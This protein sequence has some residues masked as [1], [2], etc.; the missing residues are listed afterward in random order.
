MNNQYGQQPGAGQYGQQPGAGQYGQQPG[1]S[2]YGQQPGQFVQGQAP[3]QYGQQGAGQYGQQPGAGQYGQQ[4]P[5]Q[6]GVPISQP[7]N[8]ATQESK[9]EKK[10]IKLNLTLKAKDLRNVAGAFK[11]MSDPYAT[12]TVFSYRSHNPKVIGKTEVVKNTLSP[13][14]IKNFPLDYE[15]GTSMN[16]VINIFDEVRKGKNITMGSAAID[17]N[18]LLGATGNVMAVQMK[19]GGTIIARLDEPKGTGTLRLK[20][21]GSKLKNVEGGFLGKSDPFFQ[22]MKKRFVTTGYEWDPVYKSNVVMDNLNP[23]WKED[24]IQLSAL[25]EGDLDAPLQLVCFDHERDG[26]HTPM[27][28][29][30]TT[31]NDIVRQKN[32]KGFYLVN[33]KGK[34]VGNLIVRIAE[35][36]GIEKKKEVSKSVFPSAPPAPVAMVAQSF[37]VAAPTPTPTPYTPTPYTPVR[38]QPP[39]QATFADY[40]RG[41]CEMSLCVAIDFT[42][43]NGDPRQPGTLHHTNP[44]QKND[45]EKA[46]MAIGGVLA[47]YDTDNQFPVWGFGAKYGG[48]VYH[49]FQCGPTAEVHGVNGILE[50]Y[51]QTFQS[52][53]VMSSPTDITQVIGTAGAYAKKGQA[54][55][56]LQGKNKY[57]ILLIL[58]DGA[59]SD[60]NA[61]IASLTAASDAPLSIVIVGIG[62]ADFSSMQYLDDQGSSTDI[63]QFVEFNAHRHDPNSLTAATLAEIPDQLVTYFQRGGIPPPPP[64]QVREEDIQVVPQEEEIDLNFNFDANGNPELTSGGYIPVQTY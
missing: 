58:T 8:N 32:S 28:Q 49:L 38:S 7:G 59:V 40:M 25:C 11:G 27:G 47:N 4:P 14:W 54:D 51:H 48:Q 34:A 53:L 60:I 39:P 18:K 64:V 46:I 52:G 19:K 43:S 63:V 26:N 9:P 57:S 1:A 56:R 45:Y 33:T 31:V 35:L 2:Q 15:L 6:Y 20:L 10:Q 12:V 5:S 29:V 36:N 55:A 3:S 44:N 37:V 24:T 16:V 50:A 17:I 22:L 21:S 30:E 41:G 61:T 23:V 42:G 13:S 62:N